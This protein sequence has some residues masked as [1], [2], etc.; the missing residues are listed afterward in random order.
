[1]K[2]YTFNQLIVLFVQ[3]YYRV[4]QMALKCAA[5]WRQLVA[6][7]RQL[8]L[9]AGNRLTTAAESATTDVSVRPSVSN[10]AAKPQPSASCAPLLA[11]SDGICCCLLFFVSY[12]Y[13]TVAVLGIVYCLA[14]CWNAPKLA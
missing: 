7:R 13:L 4:H 5:H 12:L 1:M 8:R 6:R 2:D 3:S 14:P 10:T 11:R 9:A